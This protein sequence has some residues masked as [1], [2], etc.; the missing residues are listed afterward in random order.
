MQETV[1]DSF[2]LNPSSG[3]RLGQV[4]PP[5]SLG[6][7]A[8]FALL[9]LLITSGV[10]WAYIHFERKTPTATGEIAR[11]AIYPVQARISGTAGM[12]GMS[13]QD[14]TYNQILVFAHV[15]LHNENPNPMTIDD[16]WGVVTLANGDTRRSLGA[17]GAD[18]DKVFLAYPQLA[19]LRMDP[20]RRNTTIASHQSADGLLVF[21]Y[22][23][24]RQEWDSRK[25]MNVTISF[26]GA[27]ELLLTAPRN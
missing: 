6:R 7:L 12:P 17:S 24:S 16:D 20:L 27:K 22:P 11:L 19:P 10:L 9:A 5:A 15:Q 14:E 21:S 4:D 23:L 2:D 13:G 18:F 26:A 1:S 25:A 8:V 3:P